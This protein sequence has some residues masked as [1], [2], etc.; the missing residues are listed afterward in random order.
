MTQ[1]QQMKNVLNWLADSY[2][3]GAGNLNPADLTE[4]F[5]VGD[6]GNLTS[7]NDY[8][9]FAEEYDLEALAEFWDE[10]NGWTFADLAGLFD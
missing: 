3:Q 5:R 8:E 10:G 2:G 1:Y 9:A 6:Y 4:F 7:V